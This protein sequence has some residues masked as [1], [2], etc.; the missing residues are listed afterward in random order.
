MKRLRNEHLTH[1]FSF[2]DDVEA[3]LSGSGAASL[4]VEDDALPALC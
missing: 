2:F 4:E 3:A 1:F